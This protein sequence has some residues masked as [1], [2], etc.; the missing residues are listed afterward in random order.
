MGVRNARLEELRRLELKTLEAQFETIAREGLN[1]SPF[2]SQAIV[3]AVQEVFYP[4]FDGC[5]EGGK[6]PPGKVTLVAVSAGE[7][8]GK[9]IGECEKQAVTL[10]LHRGAEDDRLLQEKGPA[11]WRRLR[12]ADL[13]EEAFLQ[14]ALLT[15][16]D[17][18][19][20][21]FFVSTRTISRDLAALRRQS[22]EQ[23][24]PLRSTVQDIGP[25]I[26]HRVQIVRWALKGKTSTQICDLTRHS[27]AA[28]DNYVGTFIRCAQLRKRGLQAGEIAFLLRR[29]EG[30][31]RRYVELLE[32]CGQDRNMGYHLEEFLALSR[33]GEKKASQAKGGRP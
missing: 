1:C 33:S 12:L 20:R 13:C 24:I 15:R 7:P 9:S 26:S 14:G 25:V 18:A 11:Q 28:V 3:E 6:A 31:I 29:G 32:E 16:E 23:L 17:L 2:E 30:L 21:V 4:F 19:Y 27:L 22:P 10:T 5:G 8:A